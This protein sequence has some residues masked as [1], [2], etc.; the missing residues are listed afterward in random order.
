MNGVYKEVTKLFGTSVEAYILAS[1]SKQGYD[2]WKQSSKEEREEVLQRW[3][4]LG[5]E[6]ES[7]A[8]QTPF[9]R[10]WE[11]ATQVLMHAK[12]HPMEHLKEQLK[13]HL[14]EGRICHKRSES[15]AA[16]IE[17]I[18]PGNVQE[19]VRRASHLLSDLV[20]LFKRDDMHPRRHKKPRASQ[21]LAR[22]RSEDSTD[23]I[24]FERA[25]RSSLA[26]MRSA[27]DAG[28]SENAYDRAIQVGVEAAREHCRKSKSKYPQER[29][30]PPSPSSGKRGENTQTERD[31]DEAEA[32][33]L[34]DEG[35][36][37]VTDYVI[38][39]TL[40]EQRHTQGG[41]DDQSN[42]SLHFPS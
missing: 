18:T 2:E 10:E 35:V 32:V 15:E 20:R 27:Q 36:D 26:E 40:T 37:D 21:G 7:K 42:R 29:S 22:V 6:L 30:R 4:A 19:A 14:E 13:E 25:L 31:K 12:E 28:D 39:R 8:A 3:Y 16:Q 5:V 24:M 33:R 34:A 41:N 11:A 38:W 17:K 1:R 23:D 9:A